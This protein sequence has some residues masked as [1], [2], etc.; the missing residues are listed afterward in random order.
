[1]LRLILLKLF[2]VLLPFVLYGLYVWL[3]HKKKLASGQTWNEAPFLK[4]LAAGL[5]VM[6]LGVFSWRLITAGEPGGT[7]VPARVEDGRVVP[8]R[9]EPDRPPPAIEDVN[10]ETQQESPEP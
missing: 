8:G 6:L 4:L 1:M 3:V 7:Y 10:D 5:V 2:L 9:V